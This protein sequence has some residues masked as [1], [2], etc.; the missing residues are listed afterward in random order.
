VRV[1]A[2]LC[3]RLCVCM[4]MFI[5]VFN[6]VIAT[7]LGGD[8]A[9]ASNVAKH[10]FRMEAATTQISTGTVSFPSFF[11]LLNFEALIF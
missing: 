6:A 9:V 8:V 5:R 4:H 10:K 11:H 3:V 1:F 2:F 7:L